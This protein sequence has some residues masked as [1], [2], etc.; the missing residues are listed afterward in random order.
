MFLCL[1]VKGNEPVSGFSVAF[2]VEALNFLLGSQS[3][4]ND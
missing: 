1:G 3:I 4:L 2:S